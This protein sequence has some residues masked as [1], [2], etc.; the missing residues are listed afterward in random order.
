MGLSD[1]NR[2]DI[3]AKDTKTGHILLVIIAVGDWSKDENM[4]T[5]LNAKLS[6]YVLFIKSSNYKNQ[7]GETEAS[8][9][10]TTTHE[11]TEE[12]R[13]LVEEASS[14]AKIP[15]EIVLQ[16]QKNFFR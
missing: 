1:V 3:V 7:F 13:K 16:E 8:I 2:I 14:D 15:I 5:Q 12:V 11:P 10:L 6:N 4:L 9:Q